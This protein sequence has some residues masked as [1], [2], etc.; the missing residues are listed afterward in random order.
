[1]S[2]L[3]FDH[4]SQHVIGREDIPNYILR[5][6][7]AAISA[8]SISQPGLSRRRLKGKYHM[9][10]RSGSG[11]NKSRQRLWRLAMSFFMR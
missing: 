9:F 2:E 11:A 4:S 8:A 6:N 10:R 5:L 3:E 1:M 7:P